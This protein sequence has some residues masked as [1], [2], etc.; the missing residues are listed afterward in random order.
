MPALSTGV[1]MLDRQQTERVPLLRGLE[2]PGGELVPFSWRGERAAVVVERDAVTIELDG[3]RCRLDSSNADRASLQLS[4]ARSLAV[5]D[6]MA[7][8]EA[9]CVIE[10]RG[11]AAPRVFSALPPDLVTLDGLPWMH[12][13]KGAEIP[14][15][16]AAA[17]IASAVGLGAGIARWDPNALGV[18]PTLESQRTLTPWASLLGRFSH[19]MAA[20]GL[21]VIA[22]GFVVTAVGLDMY[23]PA[24]TETVRSAETEGR[25]L[26]VGDEGRKERDERLYRYHVIYEWDGREHEANNYAA[27]VELEVGDSVVVSVDPD[28]P[29]RGLIAED[30]VRFTEWRQSSARV[31]VWLGPIATLLALIM[32][33]FR[34][35]NAVPSRLAL[36]VATLSGNGSWTY[37]HDGR[38]VTL[39]RF[40][41]GAATQRWVR[42]D[43]GHT[44]QG[45]L[46]G[47]IED[48]P[49]PMR[50]RSA[51]PVRGVVYAAGYAAAVCGTVWTLVVAFL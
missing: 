14:F 42:I 17:L 18:A 50:L 13:S 33:G 28:A 26:H 49:E 8:L 10:V 23:D 21:L 51:I 43:D 12:Q 35:T 20:A 30:G 7:S 37:R 19:W 3:D 24:E 44:T 45:Q 9:R 32:L 1:P 31:M 38:E 39:M 46:M 27:G 48:Y 11:F 6:G 36:A 2:E 47:P 29:A 41:D 40:P 15:E 25:V 4:R 34:A 5:A 16:A 22:L